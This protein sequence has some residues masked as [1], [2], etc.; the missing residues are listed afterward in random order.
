MSKVS[1]G[2]FIPRIGNAIVIW[3]KVY[4]KLRVYFDGMLSSKKVFLDSSN[5][6]ETHLYVVIEVL[7]VQSSATFE[8][9]LDEELIELW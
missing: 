3:D 6:I 2:I 5:R 1:V 8:F 7:E 4:F 9:F